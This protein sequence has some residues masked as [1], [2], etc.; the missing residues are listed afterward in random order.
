MHLT[1]KSTVLLSTYLLAGILVLA[2]F[3]LQSRNETM[4]LRREIDASYHRAFSTLVVNVT[5]MDSALQKGLYATSPSMVSSICTE[6]FGKSMAAQAALGELPFAQYHLDQTS[7]FISRVGDYAYLLSRNSATGQASTEEQQE[8][9]KKLSQ[10]ASLL[11]DNLTQLQ[12]DINAGYLSIQ[13]LEAADAAVSSLGSS[14]Q[15]IESEFP[16]LP[17]LIYDGPFSEHIAQMKPR[18]L[19]GLDPVSQEEALAIAEKFT[20]VKAS[21]FEFAGESSGNLP[22]YYFLAAV[23]GGELSI[24]ISKQG[25]VVLSMFN[26]RPVTSSALSSEEMLEKAASF[27]ETHGYDSMKESYWVIEENIAVVNYAYSQEDILCYPDLVKVHVA[28]DSGR[29]VGFEALGY[30]MSHVQRDIPAPQVSQEQAA[31]CVPSS[32]KVLSSSLA[33]IPTSGK[34]ELL[35]YEFKCENDEGRHY[36]LYVNAVTGQQ[37]K[38][39]ILIE[40]ENGTLTL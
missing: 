37:E 7:S 34:N 38:I 26:S 17:S 39:L 16:E 2:G 21:A 22:C 9:L 23:D 40:S 14:F 10:A 29:I 24:C 31:T 4:Q 1:K 35:C 15:Q 30:V 27:L 32:L 19:E 25:G 5:E 36:I 18:M 13:A 33:V 12:A 3:A 28:M 11:A 8:N 6:V 20:D